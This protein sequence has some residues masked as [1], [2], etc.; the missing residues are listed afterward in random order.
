MRRA[1]PPAAG[2]PLDA[3]RLQDYTVCPPRS[4]RPITTV[5]GERA[6][7]HQPVPD[8]RIRLGELLRHLP[9]GPFEYEERAVRRLGERPGQHQLAP[10]GRSARQRQVLGPVFRP[11]LEVIVNDV[12]HQREVHGPSCARINEAPGR[13]G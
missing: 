5:H 4:S 11:P 9:V 8:V 3:C 10:L 1:L 12:V 6:S 2:A 13:R 7:A